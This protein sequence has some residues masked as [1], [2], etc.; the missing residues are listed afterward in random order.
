MFE[1][2]SW[3]QLGYIAKPAVFLDVDGFWDPLFAQL[4]VMERHGFVRPAHRQLAQRA[5]G[6]DEA[7]LLCGAP[8]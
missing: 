6:V 1:M 7:L 8:Q 2:L 4:G 5:F 3:N